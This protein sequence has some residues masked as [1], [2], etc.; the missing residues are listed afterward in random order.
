MDKK[1][2]LRE[3]LERLKIKHKDLAAM[4]GVTP[5]TVSSWT[6]GKGNPPPEAFIYL[7]DYE[8]RK[9]REITGNLATIGGEMAERLKIATGNIKP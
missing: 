6:S 2:V 3:S 5:V 4:L 1:K 9:Y 8:N 7:L